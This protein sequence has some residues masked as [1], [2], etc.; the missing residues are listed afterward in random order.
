MHQYLENRKRY[1]QSYL[2]DRKIHALST[3]AK[4]DDLELLEVL[5]EFRG[6]LQ[7]WEATTAKR[8]KIDPRCQRQHY[9][10]VHVLFNVVF[11]ALICRRFL[12]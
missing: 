8:M 3:G 9:N 10:P 2:T 11:L 6:I 7:I 12:R 5:G 4:I 1:A